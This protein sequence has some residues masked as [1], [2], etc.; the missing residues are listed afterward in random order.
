VIEQLRSQLEQINL[1]I[2]KIEVG[3]QEYKIGGSRSVRRGELATLYKERRQL[4]TE[5]ANYEN[6]GGMYAAAFYR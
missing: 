2:S 1:A 3:A 5:L 4:Q 6:S